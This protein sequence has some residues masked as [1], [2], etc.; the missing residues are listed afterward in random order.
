MATFALARKDAGTFDDG[1]SAAKRK[2]AARLRANG[3]PNAIAALRRRKDRRSQ[4]CFCIGIAEGIC[5]TPAA[6]PNQSW[7][8]AGWDC[9]RDAGCPAPP[10]QIPAGGFLAPG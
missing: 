2:S 10:A 8:R 3:A 7:S 1:A 5:A 6:M 4:G 9:G